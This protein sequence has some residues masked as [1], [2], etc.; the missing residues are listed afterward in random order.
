[1]VELELSGMAAKAKG[2]LE[3][4][5]APLVGE[6]VLAILLG[7]LLA[8]TAWKIFAPLPLPQ[9]D[10]IAS[11]APVGSGSQTAMSVKSPFPKA[12]EAAMQTEDIAPDVAE[13]A[14]DLTLTGV[15]PAA[16]K[17][18]AIIRRPDGQQERFTLGDTIV[19]GVSLIAVYSDQVIIEQNGV[20][21]S[22]RFES[23][24]RVTQPENENRSEPPK[25]ESQPTSGSGAVSIQNL[26]TAINLRPTRSEDG[27]LV[28]AIYAGNDQ[29][30]FDRTGFQDGDVLKSINGAPA[31]TDPRALASLMNDITQSGNATITVERG[32]ETK[33][34]SLSLSGLGNER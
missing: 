30:V 34:V 16:D 15:W 29:Q 17:P 2:V 19:R 8:M 13:T 14:L 10:A 24:A 20:R 21:E 6:A 11:I 28:I 25:P 18:S 5:T 1:M 26:Q 3:G 9:G 31:P 27:E 33:T 22:L 4:R 32:G 23:K 7:A 12:E